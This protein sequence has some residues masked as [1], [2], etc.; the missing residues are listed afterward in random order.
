[1]KSKESVRWSF[2]AAGIISM[3]FA[4]VLYA[5]SILKAPLSEELGWSSSQLALNFTVTMW[6]FCIG[7]FLGSIIAKRLG[8]K[9]VISAGAILA[10]LGFA[11]SSTLSGA[12]IIPLY[13]Y[14]GIF[15]GFGIGIAYIVT[16]SA[17]SAWFPDKKGL[18]SG[19]L[20]MGFGASTML[21]GNIM[22]SMMASLGWRRAYLILGIAIAAVIA[23]AGLFIRFPSEGDAL[24]APAVKKAAAKEAFDATDMPTSQMIRRFTFWRAF[25][26]IVFLAAV[27]NTVISFARDLALSVGASVSL[28][29]TLVGVLALCNGLG[30]IL[31]GALFDL[32]GRRVTMLCACIVT[33]IAAGITLAAVAVSSL[34]LCIVGLCIVGLSYG[35]CPTLNSAFT[36]AFYG[37]KYFST[38]FSIMTFNLMGASALATAGNSLLVSFGTYSAP[39]IMLISLAAA[40][41]LLNLTIKRP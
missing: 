3:L 28:A 40:A 30:R 16:I 21:L 8:S 26:C 17:V 24:P 1:M 9:L 19:C 38:N 31:T 10:G 18:C 13:L 11:L 12:R 6:T 41:L 7:G 29:T 23:G 20:M 2:L 37:L 35:S 15:S 5:W 33:I 36:S 14:Y 22:S 4:G 25:L 27:G 34:P 39:L 32:A